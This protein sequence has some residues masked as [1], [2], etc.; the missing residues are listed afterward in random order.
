MV[1]DKVRTFGAWLRSSGMS[2]QSLSE[3]LGVS[4]TSVYKWLS[5]DMLPSAATLVKLEA[6][7]GGVVT[8]R[9]F[10]REAQGGKDDS[11]S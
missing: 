4:R 11:A 1:D 10:V 8:A 7:S 9:S 3:V 5:G 2:V 6:L